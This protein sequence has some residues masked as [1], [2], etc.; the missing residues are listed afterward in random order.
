MNNWIAHAGAVAVVAVWG[1]TFVSSKV[2][3]GYGLMPA[4]IFFYRFLMAYLCMAMVS[5]HR[6][7]S[8]SLRDE[9]TLMGLGIM[10]GSLYFL[11]ENMALV[12]STS[13]NVSI[14]V[15]TTP[16]VT[17]LLV[18]LFYRS[19]RM[20][21]LQAFG[22]LCAFMGVVLV[23]L[24]GQLYLHLN[25]RGDMLALCASC[26]WACYSLLMRR[27]M[28][29]YGA[30][31]I[32]RKVFG[33]GVLTILPWF[34]L[35]HPLEASPGVLLQVPVL[36]N[37]LFLGLVASTGGFLV[38]NRVMKVLG[39]VRITNYVYFQS[40]LTMAVGAVVLHERVTWMALLGCVVLIGGMLV[41]LRPKAGSRADAHP[42]GTAVTQP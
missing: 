15:S 3:L 9:L 16:M 32:T 38:W 4:D 29:R 7:W 11:T 34:A 13:A 22:S 1:T 26:T 25:P 20:T 21:R 19:E 30:A 37:L 27:V 41:A 35:V 31:F 42:Q 24:N 18:S 12:Y 39:P 6:M 23:V 40:L 5:H 17:A 28:L 33:Y 14:L 10:G 2:L 8:E 36:G